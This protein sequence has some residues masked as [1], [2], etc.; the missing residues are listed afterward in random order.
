MVIDKFIKLAVRQDNRNYFSI[1]TLEDCEKNKF[2]KLSDELIIPN[3]MKEFYMY[4]NPEN[5]EINTNELGTIKFYSYY[6]LKLLQK[7]YCLNEC[8]I[9]ATIDSEPIFI[10]EESIYI[11]I[12][13]HETNDE[14]FF[15]KLANN[16]LEFIDIICNDMM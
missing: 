14:R 5:V 12:Y 8:F 7:D 15:E 1:L 9:F 13:E 6:N 10:K 16:F 11:Y 4:H 2:F 3:S